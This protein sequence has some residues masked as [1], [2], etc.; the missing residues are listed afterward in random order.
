MGPGALRRCGWLHFQPPRAPARQ[1]LWTGVLVACI[2][3]YPAGRLCVSGS[4]GICV[5]VATRNSFYCRGSPCLCGVI[6]LHGL[7]NARMSARVSGLQS[8][9]PTPQDAFTRQGVYCNMVHFDPYEHE[10]EKK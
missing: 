5:T 6:G 2:L 3:T 1:E 4:T 8:P 7:L 9:I 10:A